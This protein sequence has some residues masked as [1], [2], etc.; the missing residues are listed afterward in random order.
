MESLPFKY[1]ISLVSIQ[2]TIVFNSER[3]DY[4]NRGYRKIYINTIKE[5]IKG[6]YKYADNKDRNICPGD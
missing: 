3:K 5:M 1:N 6:N 4:R 2:Y